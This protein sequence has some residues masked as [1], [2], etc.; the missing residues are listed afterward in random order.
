MQCT[1]EITD[2]TV[3]ASEENQNILTNK[4]ININ[5]N[6][7]ERERLY[8]VFIRCQICQIKIKAK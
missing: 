3:T 6:Q 8:A 1:T 7:P 5:N 2:K 4:A